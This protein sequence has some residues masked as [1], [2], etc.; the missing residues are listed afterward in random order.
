MLST[1][2]A[3]LHHSIPPIL[4][5]PARSNLP[6]VPTCCCTATRAAAADEKHGNGADTYLH[7]VGRAGRFGTKGLAITFVASPADSEVLNQVQVR[8]VVLCC[9][10]VGWLTK[11]SSWPC[12]KCCLV[13]D[14]SGCFLLQQPA[15]K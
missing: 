15:E 2:V 14:P 5:C 13:G 1:R 11:F 7:R 9:S 4:A 12:S 3:W 8:S 10:L 6:A